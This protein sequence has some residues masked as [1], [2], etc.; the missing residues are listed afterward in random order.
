[1]EIFL[2]I[3]LRTAGEMA[4]AN[5]PLDSRSK[6]LQMKNCAGMEDVNISELTCIGMVVTHKPLE[7][8]SKYNE[9]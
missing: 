4:S 8:K 7:G 9:K 6:R 3:L 1:M 5:V 2:A